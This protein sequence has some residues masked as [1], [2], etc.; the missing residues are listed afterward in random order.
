[1]KADALS[2]LEG[3]NRVPARDD[4]DTIVDRVLPHL[5]ERPYAWMYFSNTAL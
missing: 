2:K 3:A 5:A 1:M 4:D